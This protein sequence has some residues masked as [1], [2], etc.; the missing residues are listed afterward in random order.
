MKM[1]LCRILGRPHHGPDPDLVDPELD[2]AG[3]DPVGPG[4]VRV[5]RPSKANDARIAN[6]RAPVQEFRKLSRPSKPFTVR[7]AMRKIQEH[8]LTD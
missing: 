8:L 7:C 1:S 3:P 2:Q 6:Y 4:H 5:S